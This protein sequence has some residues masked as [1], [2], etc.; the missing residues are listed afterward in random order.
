MFSLESS[1]DKNPNNPVNLVKRLLDRIDRTNRNHVLP[2]QTKGRTESL[3]TQGKILM[4]ML[5]LESADCSCRI[6]NFEKMSTF[7]SFIP[8]GRRPYRPEAG[9]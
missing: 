1:K 8:P 7:L 3:S 5:G 4:M 9:N 2:F 6:Q